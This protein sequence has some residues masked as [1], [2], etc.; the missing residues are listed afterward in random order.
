M[1]R[2]RRIWR[3]RLGVATLGLG[4]LLGI[5][6]GAGDRMFQR[7]R[8]TDGER[9]R[10][11][12]TWSG[13][14]RYVWDEADDVFESLEG[15]EDRGAE[16]AR[17]GALVFARRRSP[18]NWTLWWCPPGE[19]EPRPAFELEVG[20]N[21]VDPTWSA[22]GRRVVFASDRDGGR[23]GYDLWI[24]DRTEDGL[25]RPRPIPGPVNGPFDER[26][27]ALHP[28]TGA[29]VFSS[30]RR[31]EDGQRFSLYASPVVGAGFGPP[32]PFEAL[33]GWDGDAL[34]A[35][36][37]PDGRLLYFASDASG[38]RG[39]YD[40]Y[41]WIRG[42]EGLSRVEPLTSLNGRKDEMDP[43]VSPDG[44]RLLFV[45]CPEETPGLNGRLHTAVIR[46]VFQMSEAPG[47]W[48]KSLIYALAAL[49]VVLMCMFLLLR[50]E[51]LHPFIKF[52]L[53][54]L[55][56]HLL[57]L[58]FAPR[59]EEE[60][61]DGGEGVSSRYSFSVTRE[62]SEGPN[63]PV[64]RR[65]DHMPPT[66]R[67]EDDGR[68]QPEATT[69]D[70]ASPPRPAL[71]AWSVPAPPHSTAKPSR[72]GRDEPLVSRER[73]SVAG[74]PRRDREAT[75]AR[76]SPRALDVAARR[77]AARSES[78][79]SHR[80][81][82]SMAS[83]PSRPDAAGVR[84]QIQS[85]LGRAAIRHSSTDAAEARW[86]ALSA[87]NPADPGAAR[88]DRP[89]PSER[90]LTARRVGTGAVGD[91]DLPESPPGAASGHRAPAPG[92]PRAEGVA[93]GRA[94]V[95]VR[96]GSVVDATPRRFTEGLEGLSANPSGDV[97][98][99]SVTATLPSKP[100]FA[101]RRF[102]ARRGGS[103]ETAGASFGRVRLEAM[104]EA[105]A[106]S[107]TGFATRGVPT[108]R[109]SRS[110]GDLASGLP[111]AVPGGR[112]AHMAGPTSR[113]PV[114]R[115]PTSVRVPRSAGFDRLPGVSSAVGSSGPGLPAVLG[116]RPHDLKALAPRKREV[117]RP[118]PEIYAGRRGEAKQRALEEG[119]GSEATEASVLAGLRYLAS[120][121]RSNGAWGDGRLHDKYGDRRAGKT[122]LALLAFLGAGHDG[123]REGE[124]K[125][126]VSRGLDF[127]L[128]E[129][130]SR[131]H[132]GGGSSYSHG[133][134]TYALAEA[135]ILTRDAR[136][137]RPLGRAVRRII[138]AQHRG[139]GRLD[140][141]WGYF[142]ADEARSFDSYPRLSVSAWQIM[143]LASAELGGIG[144]VRPALDRATRF[145]EAA[146]DPGLNAFRYNHDPKWLRSGYP[147]L[148]G[149][150]AAAVFALGLLD[151]TRDDALMAAGLR[152]ILQRP[153]RFRWRTPPSRDFV[154]KAKGNLY[155][156][157]Y[158][159]LALH[160]SGG[161]A[162]R[163]WNEELK[164]LLTKNQSSDGSWRPISPYAE[165]AGDRNGDRIYT[166]SLAV[167][168]LEVYYRYLT[169][170][171]SR[172]T[173]SNAV[174]TETFV[175]IREVRPGSTAEQAGLTAGDV[176]LE[177]DGT[178]VEKPADLLRL[179]RGAS[180]KA[181]ATELLLRREGRLSR[182]R[183]QGPIGGI[184]VSSESST[185]ERR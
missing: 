73:A 67:R 140:G 102:E 16:T 157:Y 38:G 44:R 3:K 27:P 129:Q 151:P 170:L 127:L 175:V 14:M 136:L 139:G 105:S 113:D 65:A 142:Y 104:P 13:A 22:D 59:P 110:G 126:T 53:L 173:Q 162:W 87:R 108:P 55:V 76:P 91:R 131:G 143:A 141:G 85:A 123:K 158:A 62:E 33:V 155:F 83:R 74:A 168:T 164:R 163:R 92:W 111:A 152:H 41:R 26:H 60:V 4:I 107:A 118:W 54:S 24:A 29:L 137:R 145:L 10:K 51:R 79:P 97:A 135:W 185:H 109:P 181:E 35:S 149:S 117:E 99:G 6:W 159:A 101:P 144:G 121:Q 98:E 64:G 43:S 84:P 120:K 134:A 75:A 11:P 28:L 174:R 63:A 115:G 166:T 138:R 154:A 133:I 156:H 12:E 9:L 180:G 93:P 56:A 178:T 89:A 160:R 2:R 37:S 66:A 42:P 171:L 15:V 34:A 176:I 165:Y 80:G 70:G 147:T 18:G 30:N 88:P 122:G 125:D 77:T 45:R 81:R 90:L 172:D 25:S 47:L 31:S 161:R 32:A 146:W 184:G 40:L 167:L 96:G 82:P 153:P 124:F 132:V 57:F 52:L 1:T 114:S 112:R 150:S 7:R 46:E 106:P 116:Q 179:L 94:L 103:S 119:G 48:W 95:A 58:L 19:S 69:R 71:A 68:W 169:P 177:V 148:P 86:N 61:I 21:D 183:F 8:I 23:G 100:S 49:T 20:G 72:L 39:G 5:L 17:D 130:R 36:F 78:I 50:W 128:G 182:L